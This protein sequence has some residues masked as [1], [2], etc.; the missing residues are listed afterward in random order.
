MIIKYN[1]KEIAHS[2]ALDYVSAVMRG[3]LVSSTGKQK[4][5]CHV[6]VFSG[7]RVVYASITKAGTHVFN[8]TK[9]K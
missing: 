6:S 3:G 4:H 7:D 5:Y 1:E 8:V 2:V 9:D